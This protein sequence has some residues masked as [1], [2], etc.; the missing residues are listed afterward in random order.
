MFGENLFNSAEYWRYGVHRPTRKPRLATKLTR[1][2]G[3]VGAIAVAA[4]VTL[5]QLPRPAPA[6]SWHETTAHYSVYLGLVSAAALRDEPIEAAIHQISLQGLPANALHV[7]VAVYQLSDNHRVTD[8]RVTATIEDNRLRQDVAPE[9]RFDR[10]A[11]G[12][13]LTYCQFFTLNKET[14]RKHGGFWIRVRVSEPGKGKPE[15][16]RFYQEAR[17]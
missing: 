13:A 15:V 11:R 2:I 14:Q 16:A 8:A 5:T 12:G 7:M 17:L 9:K 3:I 1:R 4:V 10:M 6:A